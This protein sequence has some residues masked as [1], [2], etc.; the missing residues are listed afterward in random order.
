MQGQFCFCKDI[1]LIT[2]VNCAVV[3]YNIMILIFL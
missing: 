3:N 2:S 1:F